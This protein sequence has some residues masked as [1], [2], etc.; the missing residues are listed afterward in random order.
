MSPFLIGGIGFGKPWTSFY[1]F[2]FGLLGKGRQGGAPGGLL[3]AQ[4]NLA[5]QL[6]G[7]GE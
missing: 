4:S 5:G 2:Y 7:V 1:F 6:G 3:E